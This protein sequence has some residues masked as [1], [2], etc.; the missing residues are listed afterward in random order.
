VKL[1]PSRESLGIRSKCLCARLYRYKANVNIYVLFFLWAWSTLFIDTPY[2]TKVQ[3]GFLNRVLLG[4]GL[5]LDYVDKS[6]G[7]EALVISA[8]LLWVRVV[9]L[10]VLVISALLLLVCLFVNTFFFFF[11]MD[12]LLSTRY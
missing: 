8:L 11:L 10:W 5:W 7:L 2:L 4:R 1:V 12:W 9:S 3:Q 6:S